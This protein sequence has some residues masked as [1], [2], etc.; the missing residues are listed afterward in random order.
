MLDVGRNFAFVPALVALAGCMTNQSGDV[1]ATR[2]GDLSHP[3]AERRAPD[4]EEIARC[5]TGE[6]L[7]RAEPVVRRSPYL[8]QLSAS[9]T[10]I[11]WTADGTSPASVQ[12]AAPADARSDGEPPAEPGFD[13][14]PIVGRSA[15][16]DG[17]TAG[18]GTRAY[19]SAVESLLPDT[20]YCYQLR[21]GDAAATEPAGFRTAPPPGVGATVAFVAFG[22]SGWA[23]ADQDAILEQ[24][25][26]V[27]FRLIVHT[28]DIAYESGSMSE[29]EA[30]FFD[31]YAPLLRSFPAFPAIGNHDDGAVFRSA[32]DLPRQG[33]HNWYSFD[34]GDVHFVALDTNDM[35]DEQAAWLDRDLAA[36]DREW[37]IV[38]GH[39]P[40][41]SSGEH[42]S[43]ARF[44]EL[45]GPILER[46]RVDLVLSGHDHDYER[47]NPQ[48]GVHYVVTGGG[49]RGTRPVGESDFTAF[50]EQVLH[51]VYVEV[52][53]QELLLHA[54]DATGVE[55][56]QLAISH[57]R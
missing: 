10:R 21:N 29:L 45:F 36:T 57:A 15:E 11:L 56:D 35:T 7:Q 22:D 14:A 55:F 52:V 34:F 39:H 33:D 54:I 37:R 53:G 48:N 25:G 2:T 20:L 40:P 26:T 49:G 8:Q 24:L 51:F 32:Y 19:A 47:V 3:L 27:P 28:G 17:G 12:V 1:E 43:N 31:V 5:G 18:D 16:I 41:F 9:G 13:L 38:Y 6:S 46:H 4:A 42:G 30:T 23:G 44:R 50:S